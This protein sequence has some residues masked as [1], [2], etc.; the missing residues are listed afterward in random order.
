VCDAACPAGLSPRA[1]AV[2][3]RERLARAGLAAGSA[4]TW[5]PGIDRALLT[6]RL[7]LG[8]YD[9]PVVVRIA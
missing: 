4:T 9:R 6:L 2:D 1:L 8:R 5:K 7:G 3:V